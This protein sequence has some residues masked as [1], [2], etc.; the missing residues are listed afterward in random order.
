MIE[1]IILGI[2]GRSGS[3]KTTLSNHIQN[4]LGK[5][6]VTIICQDNYYHD[7]GSIPPEKR[8]SIN[9]DHPDA[10]DMELFISHVNFLKK[11]RN[12][13][14]PRYN[15]QTHRRESTGTYTKPTRILIFE[16]I[17]IYH[18]KEVRENIRIK[19][20]VDVAKDLCLIRRLDRDIKTRQRS[21][22][23]VITQYLATVRP[24]QEL[25]VS[26]SIQHADWIIYEGMKDIDSIDKLIR[27]VA[28]ESGLRI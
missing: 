16:G 25:F 2:G 27:M 17:H 4:V 22:E 1:S 28:S 18:S 11:G 5:Q 8:E 13:C 6:N 3:G 20:F 24:M 19:A 10:L 14:V 9:Y 21:A 26:P 12:V 23:S 15:Y 7:Q